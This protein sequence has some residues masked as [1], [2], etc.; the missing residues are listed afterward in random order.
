VNEHGL[1]L[2]LGGGAAKGLAHIGVL[3]G[4][5]EDGVELEGI[6]GTSMG[7]IIGALRAQG[8]RA[9][10]LDALVRSI[11]W[12]RLGRIMVTS[13]SG[14]AF[15]DMLRE[16]F[17]GA[18]IEDLELPFAAVCA[19]LDTGE[20][21]VLDSGDLAEAVC[22][23]SSIPG[24]LPA[25]T[26]GGRRLV[27]GAISEPVPVTA[28]SAMANGGILAVSVVRPTERLHEGG[29]IMTSMPIRLEVPSIFRRVE[30]WLRRQRTGRIEDE[31]SARVSRWEAVFR[32]FHIMQFRLAMCSRSDAPMLE[33]RVGRFGWFDFHRAEEII[34]A[35]YV[36]YREWAGGGLRTGDSTRR[37]PS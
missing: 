32:S 4:M 10:D 28:A 18:R 15:R 5:E 24:I 23:S 17:R 34:D 8:L 20:M 12:V 2:A 26:I 35:G 6:A 30:G 21:V 27:D 29:A 33:P 36:S 14:A 11:D 3:K 16:T 13:V 25:R 37:N 9:V 1:T 31:L 22:A 19:D 7:A